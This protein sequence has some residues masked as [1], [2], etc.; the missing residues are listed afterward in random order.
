[1]PLLALV[2][3]SADQLP[4]AEASTAGAAGAATELLEVAGVGAAVGASVSAAELLPALEIVGA[5]VVGARVVLA[6]PW[7]T[8]VVGIGPAVELCVGD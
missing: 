6:L 8:F 5:L 4:E 1:M 3:C 2:G 7:L